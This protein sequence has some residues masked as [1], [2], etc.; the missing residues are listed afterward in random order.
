MSF[1]CSNCDVPSASRP[2]RVVTNV[3]PRRYHI[4]IASFS[5]GWEIVAERN[6][7]DDCVKQHQPPIVDLSQVTEE[8][9]YAAA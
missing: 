3:R 9:A 1:R 6:L 2:H 5:Y 4:G 7:C 8:T